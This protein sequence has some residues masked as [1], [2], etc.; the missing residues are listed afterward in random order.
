MGRFIQTGLVGLAIF[1]SLALSAPPAKHG[2]FKHHG[3]PVDTK[4]KV[5]HTSSP[6]SKAHVTYEI[7]VG[8]P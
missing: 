4:D 1:S 8:L 3:K 7:A 5:S 2:A 6:I